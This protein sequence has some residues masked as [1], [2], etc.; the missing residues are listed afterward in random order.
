[1]DEKK[2]TRVRCDWIAGAVQSLRP[3]IVQLPQTNGEQLHDFT[4]KVFIRIRLLKRESSVLNER[5]ILAHQR[6]ERHYTTRNE[7]VRSK[8]NNEN[9]KTFAQNVSVVS[10][11]IAHKNVIVVEKRLVF[12]ISLHSSLSKSHDLRQGPRHSLSQLVLRKK[13]DIRPHHAGAHV[14]RV[15]KIQLLISVNTRRTI[16]ELFFFFFFPLSE[17]TKT[18]NKH[19]W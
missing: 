15:S 9:K 7:T 14:E 4:S 18:P 13:S 12:S 2:N 16:G 8:Q 6:R 19:T 1:M 3:I 17:Q 5:Q 11:G 10:K